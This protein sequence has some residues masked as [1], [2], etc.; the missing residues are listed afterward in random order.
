MDKLLHEK[1]TKFR[2]Q[3]IS[4]SELEEMVGRSASTYTK[5]AEQI[6]KLEETG[7]LT[8][9]KSTGRNQRTPS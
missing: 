5:F 9:I 6:L 8:M 1:L 2:K 7:Y 3:K 4:V